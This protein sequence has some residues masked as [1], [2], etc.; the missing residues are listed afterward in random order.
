M[1]APR[2]QQSAAKRRIV[3]GA[4]R[5]APRRPAPHRTFQSTAVQMSVVFVNR[6]WLLFSNHTMQ[7]PKRLQK[8]GCFLWRA[9]RG[10]RSGTQIAPRASRESQSWS[11]TNLPASVAIFSKESFTNEFMIGMAFRLIPVW[12][13]GWWGLL[14]HLEDVSR[15]RRVVSVLAP[16]LAGWLG[17]FLLV[18]HF[19]LIIL[20]R[21]GNCLGLLAV[22]LRIHKTSHWLAL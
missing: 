12:G 8:Q 20:R 22:A 3:F 9:H 2:Q 14:H 16:L 15:V 11:S 18:N 21:T 13:W 4:A 7:P 6:V 10:E 17:G 19:A 5:A 1:A